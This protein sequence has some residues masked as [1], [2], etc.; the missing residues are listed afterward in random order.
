MVIFSPAHSFDSLMLPAFECP[1]VDGW[2]RRSEEECN[3]E[4]LYGI[5]CELLHEKQKKQKEYTGE[6][7]SSSPLRLC[8]LLG[9]SVEPIFSLCLSCKL[10]AGKQW[11]RFFLLF[12]LSICL[13]FVLADKKHNGADREIKTT[14]NQ[15]E[16][17]NKREEGERS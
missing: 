6:E 2:E 3:L 14:R 8:H 16:T 15:E 11:S 13:P 12:P 4:Q 7:S 1:V 5:P 17:K 9:L 10:S